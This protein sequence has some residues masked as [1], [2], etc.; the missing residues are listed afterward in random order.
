MCC[1]IG[2]ECFFL[3]SAFLLIFKS[4]FSPQAIGGGLVGGGL[5]AAMRYGIARGLFSNESGMGSAPIVAAAARTKPCTAGPCFVY[6][7]LLGHGSSMCYDGIGA[8]NQ[9]FTLSRY[10]L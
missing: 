4:A 9:Y 2:H 10:R 1:H 3:G 5:M 7:Y 6:G 8:G